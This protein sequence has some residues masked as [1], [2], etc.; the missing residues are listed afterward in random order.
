MKLKLN[1][2]NEAESLVSMDPYLRFS[3]FYT[4]SPGLGLTKMPGFFP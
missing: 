3:E 2:Q 1:E 4:F